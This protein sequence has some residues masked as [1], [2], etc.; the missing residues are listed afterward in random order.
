MSI[1]S[2]PGMYIYN[3]F[4]YPVD[5]KVFMTVIF[6]EID[7]LQYWRD[8]PLLIANPLPMTATAVNLTTT[9]M[10]AMTGNEMV[11]EVVE[12][13]LEMP[14]VMV[15][16][17]EDLNAVAKEM[18]EFQWPEIDDG[19]RR[20]SISGWTVSRETEEALDPDDTKV[21]L[22][23]IDT[24]ILLSRF[25][26]FDLPTDIP[27][28]WEEAM[29]EWS[30][31]V[32]DYIDTYDEPIEHM[33]QMESTMVSAYDSG[34]PKEVLETREGLSDIWKPMGEPSK[35]WYGIPLI[36]LGP[37]D[38]T[39]KES[40]IVGINSWDNWN[41]KLSNVVTTGMQSSTLMIDKQVPP[42]KKFMVGVYNN[43]G[44]LGLILRIEGDDKVY[45]KEVRTYDDKIPEVLSYGVDNEGIKSLGGYIWDALFWEKPINFNHNIPSPEPAYPQDGWVY[46]FTKF[47]ET[48]V[49]SFVGGSIDGNTIRTIYDYGPSARLGSGPNNSDAIFVHLEPQLE[50]TSPKFPGVHPWY[51]IYKS[52]MDGFF[53]RESLKQSDF[54]IIWHQ[55]LFQ[56]PT[57]IHALVSDSIFSN[58]LSYDYDNFEIVAEFNGRKHTE[59]ITI[60]ERMWAQMSLRYNKKLG[61]LYFTCLDYT[62]NELETV[63]FNIGTDLE[64][65]L[66]SMF[67]RFNKEDAEYQNIHEGL[68]GTVIIHE[69]FKTQEVLRDYADNI[70]GF[71]N[72][73]KPELTPRKEA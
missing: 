72:Q 68:F 39:I 12:D 60:P 24:S 54:T 26:V 27:Q 69:E 29:E 19:V 7:P 47:Y 21:S 11:I 56:Y 30:G 62:F 44:N 58:Y 15:Q 14:E 51:F 10:V 73:Y 50:N 66:I 64:F 61:E 4:D 59:I 40:F 22:K 3:S 46:D 63:T 8:R 43:Q 6:A 1:Q 2:G 33:E 55:W 52:Y 13:A 57:G 53:C 38:L 34:I 25:G 9:S 23:L 49:G 28:E 20:T 41:V 36:N 5:K 48:G 31:L 37:R 67:A 16:Q 71:L 42:N 35:Q 32:E 65:E 45:Q 17:Q 70:S 18:E